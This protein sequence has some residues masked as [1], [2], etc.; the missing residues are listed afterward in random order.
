MLYNLGAI[1][2]Y[3]KKNINEAIDYFSK[4]IAVDP[5]STEAYFARGASFEIMK[6]FEN[7]KEDYNMCLKITKN[8]EPAISA[9]NNLPKK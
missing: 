1:S 9:L 8:Y 5:K 4:A 7:A 3:K 2:L 6:D